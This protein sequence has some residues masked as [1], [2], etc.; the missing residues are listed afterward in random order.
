MEG[1]EVWRLQTWPGL[2]GAVGDCWNA[3]VR[4]HPSQPPS[5]NRVFAPGCAQ[6]PRQPERQGGSPGGTDLEKGLSGAESCS[7]LV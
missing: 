7:Q 1:D 5:G 2:W 3:K 4:D 6:S